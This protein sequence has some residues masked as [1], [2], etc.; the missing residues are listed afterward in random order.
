MYSPPTTNNRKRQLPDIPTAQ[1]NA[2][3]EKG[4]LISIVYISSSL[5]I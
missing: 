1:L 5:S 3:R 4:F 2:N